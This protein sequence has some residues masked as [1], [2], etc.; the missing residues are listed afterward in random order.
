MIF[1][2]KEVQKFKNDIKNYDLKVEQASFGQRRYYDF[3]RFDI[4]YLQDAVIFSKG[5]QGPKPN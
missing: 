5:E 4:N 2:E 1:S 3:E